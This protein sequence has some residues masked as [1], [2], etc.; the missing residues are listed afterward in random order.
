MNSQYTIVNITREFLKN[1]PL[2]DAYFK[3][4]YT[5]NYNNDNNASIMGMGI[6]A[7]IIF[8]LVAIG[9]WIWAIVS[10]IKFWNVLP[11]WAKIIGLISLLPILPVG[12]PIMTLIVVYIAK[13]N[14]YSYNFR[15]I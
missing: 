9:I 10:L 3:G 14:N 6:V 8:F 15:Y 11:D 13:G 1:K 7:F 5:E 4:Q 12:G 2:I